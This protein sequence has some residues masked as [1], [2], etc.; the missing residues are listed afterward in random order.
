MAY[1]QGPTVGL[2]LGPYG[3]GAYLGLCSPDIHAL[4]GEGGQGGDLL[5]V[6]A[7]DQRR[8]HLV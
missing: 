7:S 2:C 5:A 1:V 4:S 3:W 8:A 6:D